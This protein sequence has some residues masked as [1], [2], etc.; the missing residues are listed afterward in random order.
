MENVKDIC[1]KMLSHIVLFCF[2]A[3]LLLMILQVIFRYVLKLSVPWTDEVAR[4]LFIW[5]I[6][7]GSALAHRGKAH[8]QITVFLD[9]LPPWL[10]KKFDTGIDLFNLMV[11]IVI[12]IGAVKMMIRTYGIYLSSVPVSFTWVYLS[13]PLGVGIMLA[14]TIGSLIKRF[15]LKTS[16]V[17]NRSV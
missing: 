17:L 8:I 5:E 9:R 14:L 2:S 7:L 1:W 15:F 4:S 13:M 6:F 10:R 11:L 16:P 12:I 3:M